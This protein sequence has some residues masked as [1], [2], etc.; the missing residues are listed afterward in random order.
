MKKTLLIFGFICI[1]P[2]IVK[3]Q[4]LVP[5]PGFEIYTTCPADMTLY[6]V[7]YL[8]PHWYLPTRG[9]SD[10]FNSCTKYQV[11][12]PQNFIGNLFAF[13]GNAYA[14]IVLLEKP[15]EDKSNKN[16]LNNYR[17]YLQAKLTRAL[18]K[19]ERY[20]I[21]INYAIA[22]YSTY[23]TNGL[24]VCL[25][26]RKIKSRLSSKVLNYKPVI[27]VPREL[28]FTERGYWYTLTDTLTAG[29]NEEYITIGNFYDDIHTD[30]IKLDASMFNNSLENRITE[31]RIAY[32]Y[33][34]L[35]SVEIIKEK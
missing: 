31:N 28:I 13:E 35:V 11:G 10:Y 4:N 21:T 8:I 12:I 17:E 5:N 16:S 19:G 23:A 7:R 24:G 27:S 26:E 25:T 30:Y 6:S 15:P 2:G 33:I 9:T 14:G 20:C 29:G 22:N 3:S 34:D 18:K 1:L 32:Y